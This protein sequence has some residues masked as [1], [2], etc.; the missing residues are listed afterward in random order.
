MSA[1]QQ[2]VGLRG[3]DFVDDWAEVGRGR[4]M[5]RALASGRQMGGWF[6]RKVN[7]PESVCKF[8]TLRKW[9]VVLR[10]MNELVDGIFGRIP[11]IHNLV[12]DHTLCP[13]AFAL[14][15]PRIR[16]GVKGSALRAKESPAL[17]DCSL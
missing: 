12:A 17:W 2:R 11:R 6:V 5:S 1:A 15:N 10:T 3:D 16:H 4:R 7:S 9:L 8:I 14:A 13:V